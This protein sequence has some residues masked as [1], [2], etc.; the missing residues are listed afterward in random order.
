MGAFSLIVVINLLNRFNMSYRGTLRS[1]Q[2]YIIAEYVLSPMRWKHFSR[3]LSRPRSFF[4]D[5]IVFSRCCSTN[6]NTS[7]N[8]EK[9]TG[10]FADEGKD[11]SFDFSDLQ[12]TGWSKKE[13]LEIELLELDSSKYSEDE[14]KYLDL[15]DGDIEDDV[16]LDQLGNLSTKE[17]FDLVKPS[18]REGQK[19]KHY[20]HSTFHLQ[21][22]VALFGLNL[23]RIDIKRNDELTRIIMRTNIK[24]D[25]LPRL[26]LLQYF[27]DISI[28]ESGNIFGKCPRVLEHP[29]DSLYDTLNYY[30]KCNFPPEEMK[31]LFVKHPRALLM[32]PIGVDETLSVLQLMTDL[33]AKD[34]KRIIV[35]APRIV[36]SEVDHITWNRNVFRDKFL[37][38]VEEFHRAALDCPEI[39]LIRCERLEDVYS[40]LT[41]EMKLTN[42]LISH[43]A[44]VFK[45]Q[46]NDIKTLNLF[47]K[48]I[49]RDQYDP[50]KP[51]YVSLK[52]FHGDIFQACDELQL[53]K[54]KLVA[55]MKTL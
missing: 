5:R 3:K 40:Y 39:L 14:E 12:E 1:L 20:V 47:L 54:E 4:I 46:L 21:V 25:V 2:H 42:D 51:L 19:L 37:F 52:S 27:F 53:S 32:P 16:D 34:V 28:S 44:Q 26:N 18:L 10:S 22:F 35:S 30:K 13:R 7:F 45:T 50:T 29:L 49:N 33:P 41:T 48:S 6:F 23:H 38:N 31:K 15:V 24:N 43:S 9:L 11:A 55:F 36:T 17:L 8:Q